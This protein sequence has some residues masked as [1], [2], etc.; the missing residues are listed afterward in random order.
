MFQY[1]F[2]ASLVDDVEK[3]IKI[4]PTKTYHNVDIFMTGVII[5]YFVNGTEI[6]LPYRIYCF[7]PPNYLV[8]RLSKQ[9]KMILHCIYSRNCNGFVREK[10]INALLSVNYEDWCIPYIVKVCDEYIV[11]ILEKV[12]ECLAGQDN[13]NVK[14]FCIENKSAL[15]K[16]YAR[17]ISYWNQ[18]YRD[19]CC[20]YK[21]Y[22]GHQLFVDCFGYTLLNGSCKL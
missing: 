9:Q 17:M 19:R 8:A 6:Q 14:K 13:E 5:K 22:I 7:E 1:G 3:V 16:S 4:M 20:R 10:H 11:E 18:Y 21:N 2:P 15:A 12:Y